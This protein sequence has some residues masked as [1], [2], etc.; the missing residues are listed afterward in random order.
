MILEVAGL[1]KNFGGIKALAGV[2][3]HLD[4]G[5]LIGMIGP[6]GSGKTTVFNVITG[7][8]RPAGGSVTM[9]GTP[10]VG[11]SPH[12]INRLGIVRTFQNIRLFRNLSVMDNVRIACHS[13]VRYGPLSALC[14]SGGFYQAEGEIWEKAMHLLSI[15]SL[16]DRRKE[17]AK[18][19]PYGDQ[20]KLEIARALATEPRILL[21]DE[22]AAGMNPFEVG[23]LME[24]IREI[25]ERFR[26][27]ILL[28]EHQMRL[29]MG[30]CERIVVMD[31]G[32]VI[33]R[34]APE[35]IRNNPRVIEAYLGE[36]SG[37]EG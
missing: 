13:H 24:F 11:L 15:V 25:R 22:P 29:V 33:A 34:G 32:Q 7:I 4:E 36:G 12:A 1:S 10:L 19:L 18:N 30:I 14:R 8:Y 31:F 5:E 3:F 9:D 28:I 23:R 2:D 20:R 27:S 35:E 16:Q 6:N 26:L 17:L 21:L 37:G